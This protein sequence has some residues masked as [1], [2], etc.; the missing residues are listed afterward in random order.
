MKRILGVFLAAAV[1]VVCLSVESV[2]TQ[3]A[4]RRAG[5]QGWGANTAYGALFDPSTLVSVRGKVVSV[6]RF[7]PLRQMG[8]GLLV[9]IETAGEASVDVHVGP[10]WYVEDQDFPIQKGDAIAVRGSRI[11]FNEEPAIIATQIQIG[12]KLLLLRR[13][14]GVPVWSEDEE[15]GG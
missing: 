6:E 2:G 12:E 9:T 13:D 7:T 11:V 8:Y 10:G 14:N 1:T 4:I 5:G 3:L 15:S